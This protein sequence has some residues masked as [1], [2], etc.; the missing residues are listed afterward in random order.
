MVGHRHMVARL[1]VAFRSAK[2]AHPKRNFRRVKGDYRSIHNRTA[3]EVL[4]STTIAAIIAIPA[5]LA[6]GTWWLG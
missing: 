1:I 6:I 3:I 5:W 2:A 4:I